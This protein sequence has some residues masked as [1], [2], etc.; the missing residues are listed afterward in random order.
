M[1]IA[2][3]SDFPVNDQACK[4]ATGKT[5]SQWYSAI[6]EKFGSSF[7]RRDT[8]NW[9]YG[10][11]NKDAWWATT[12]CVEY[13]RSKGLKNKKDGL[14]EGYNICVTKT[15][16]A[17]L[18]DVYGAFAKADKLGKWFS[19]GV[20]AKVADGGSFETKDGPRGEY[21]RVRENKDLR[22]TWQHPQATSP[23]QVDVAIADKGKGKSGI[24]L[25][26]QRIQTR[27][28]ADGLRAAWGAAF[29][30]LKAL[31]EGK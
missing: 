7:A 26:H 16:A 13:E 23:T 11:T 20:K 24:T 28:E 8:V 4:K 17:P 9:V 29:D 15:I 1:K 19:P 18:A 14:P 10:E 30:E 21:L 2:F 12:I 25:N 27:E 5:L 6:D 31:L 22:F 3:A